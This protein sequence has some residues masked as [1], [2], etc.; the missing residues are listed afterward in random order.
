M[1][2]NNDVKPFSCKYCDKSFAKLHEVKEHIKIHASILETNDEVSSLATV[3]NFEFVK[4][5]CH[6][7][8]VQLAA[9][10]TLQNHI[11]SVHEGKKE[12]PCSI[13]NKDFAYVSSLKKHK[14]QVHDKVK[15]ECPQCESQLGCAW[16]LKK[17]I[18]YVHEKKKAFNCG[19]CPKQF[20]TK[21]QFTIHY[22]LH[23]EKFN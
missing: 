14:K 17:H 23:H 22:N 1:E 19:L 11:K 16:N 3:H 13:C 21:Q 15:F 5:P 18:E 7:C 6:I 2:R 8:G 4:H 10:K 20:A 9:K 12:F